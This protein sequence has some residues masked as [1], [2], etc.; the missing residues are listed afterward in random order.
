MIFPPSLAVLASAWRSD[1]AGDPALQAPPIAPGRAGGARTP[2]LV[3]RLVVGSRGLAR[4]AAM[5]T[6]PGSPA[7]TAA[8]LDG[9]NGLTPGA[10]SPRP[11][12]DKA[13][14]SHSAILS[15]K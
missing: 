4:V 7:A 14:E 11:H 9:P 6:A 15:V 12:T 2:E 5:Q 3:A 10:P 1:E 13:A 8:V